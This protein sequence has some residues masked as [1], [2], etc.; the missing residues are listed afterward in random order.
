M[1]EFK[2]IA[3]FDKEDNSL[4]Y[5]NVAVCHK[6]AIIDTKVELIEEKG[7]KRIGLQMLKEDRFVVR[8]DD[9]VDLLVWLDTEYEKLDF[10]LKGLEK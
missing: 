3:I 8:Q 4:D 6:S 1:N 2:T 5:Y 7:F 10:K 9:L